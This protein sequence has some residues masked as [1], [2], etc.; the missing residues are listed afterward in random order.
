MTTS[1]SKNQRYYLEEIIVNVIG[2][3]FILLSLWTVVG[4]AAFGGMRSADG[5]ILFAI[6][7]LQFFIG[8][9]LV[10]RQNRAR[11]AAIIFLICCSIYWVAKKYFLGHNDYFYQYLLGSAILCS[12]LLNLNSVKK[13]FK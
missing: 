4:K 3:G 1:K 2:L 13:V 12:V 6:L 10:S 7:P 9:G 8:L 5:G 11:G